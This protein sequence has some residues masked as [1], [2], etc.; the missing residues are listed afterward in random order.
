MFVRGTRWGNYGFFKVAY[1]ADGVASGWHDVYGFIVTPSTGDVPVAAPTP[2]KTATRTQTATST[3][4]TA[5]R[6]ATSTAS[7]TKTS[8]PTPAA[9]TP[10]GPIAT[11]QTKTK[12][13][14]VTRTSTVAG[15]ILGRTAT[16][17][18]DYILSLSCGS[19]LFI[20]I[21]SAFYGRDDQ[22]TCL[23]RGWNTSTMCGGDKTIAFKACNGVRSCY[24][25]INDRTMGA[26]GCPW[27]TVKFARVTYDC[28]PASAFK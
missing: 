9:F 19:N 8:T 27:N 4:A 13:R 24:G 14:T 22:T 25:Y 5:T 20:K 23:R 2:T 12:S 3:S 21:T 15:P 10:V 1:G 7:A 17:C 26:S 11:T 16:Q 28:L 6:T 18:Q